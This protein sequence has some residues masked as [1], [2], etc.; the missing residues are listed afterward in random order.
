[1]L[2]IALLLIIFLLSILLLI[3]FRKSSRLER[4][5]QELSFSKS[6]QAVKY[7]KM[8]EQF[9]PFVEELPFASSNFR[10]IGSPIDGIAFEPDS[11]IFCE[12]KAANGKLSPLQQNIKKLVENKC[13]QWLEFR[14]RE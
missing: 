8:T 13:I 14:I 1:M 11:I 6:S 5:L 9:V 2:L 10:F 7:G 3:F 4:A 12:F